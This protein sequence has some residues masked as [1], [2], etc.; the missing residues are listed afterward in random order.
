MN[1]HCRNEGALINTNIVLEQWNN[2]LVYLVNISV[3]I[4]VCLAKKN[5]IFHGTLILHCTQSYLTYYL[6]SYSKSSV[7]VVRYKV[8][9]IENFR[10]K[11]PVNTY[12]INY[13]QG[14]PLRGYKFYFIILLIYASI[15][16]KLHSLSK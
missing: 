10:I 6:F 16:F 13:S 1:R 15:I 11:Q 5:S 7:E 8:V 4:I 12:I 2:K 14:V 9:W 3:N